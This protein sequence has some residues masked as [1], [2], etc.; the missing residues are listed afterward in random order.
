MKAFSRRIVL[1]LAGLVLLTSVVAQAQSVTSYEYA[2]G[3]RATPVYQVSYKTLGDVVSNM[4]FLGLFTQ[5]FLLTGRYAVDLSIRE[6]RIDHMATSSTC[7]MKNRDCIIGLSF[8]Q[9]VGTNRF[10]T[11]FDV[12]L[13]SAPSMVA[14]WAPA[15]V[16]D[17]VI[18]LANEPIQTAYAQIITSI[19]F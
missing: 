9:P 2:M 1:A 11:R 3:N 8:V 14:A 19:R 15:T 13:L 6:M 5:S 7:P 17:Y 16:G 4:P 10:S 12:P 18:H